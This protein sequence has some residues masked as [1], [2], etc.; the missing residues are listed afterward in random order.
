[1]GSK[2]HDFHAA[3]TLLFEK[4]AGWMGKGGS[5]ML[6][7]PRPLGARIRRYLGAVR[8]EEAFVQVQRQIE[9]A[10]VAEGECVVML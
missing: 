7:P 10:A 1:M 8:L 5:M 6:G 4:A 9:S 2:C 3:A